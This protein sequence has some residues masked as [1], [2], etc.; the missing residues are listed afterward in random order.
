MTFFAWIAAGFKLGL[1]MTAMSWLMFNWLYGAGQLPRDA[2]H[3]AIREHLTTIK[4]HHKANKPRHGNYLYKQWLFFGGGFY[5]LAVLWTLLIIEVRELLLFI[6]NFDL[7]TLLANGI[8]AL[9]ISLVAA[10]L[11]NIL[12]ALLWF[13]YWPG[14]GGAILPWIAMAYAGYLWGIHLARERQSLHS[15]SDLLR[16]SKS[17]RRE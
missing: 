6:V 16:K 13:G 4:K 17:G 12:S 5:G 15:L 2:G 1:P 14:N 9:V 3:Q 11:S 10:Q 8:A 7:A